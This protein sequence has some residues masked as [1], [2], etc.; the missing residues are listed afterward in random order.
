MVGCL[1]SSMDCVGRAYLISDAVPVTDDEHEAHV[2]L[3]E[4]LRVGVLG[5]DVDPVRCA[6]SRWMT[7]SRVGVHALYHFGDAVDEDGYLIH[8][9][10]DLRADP[11]RALHQCHWPRWR[12]PWPPARRRW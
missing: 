9:L 4:V 7:R 11:V 8:L 1:Q 5:F 10:D 12:G 3:E 2:V 6:R